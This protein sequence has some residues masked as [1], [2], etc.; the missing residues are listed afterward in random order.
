LKRKDKEIFISDMTDRLT[1]AR[2]TFLVDYQGLDVEAMNALRAELKKNQA[3]LFVVKNRLVKRACKD[4]DTA[5]IMEEFRGPCALTIAYDEIIAPAKVLVAREKKLDHLTI[6][7]GQIAGKSI[8]FK[9]IK[10]LA[11]LPGREVLLAQA[12]SA[13]QAVPASV[14][15]VLNAVMVNFLN[16]LKA[17][18][19]QQKDQEN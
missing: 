12:L 15:R 11:A 9:E 5:S 7:A 14:V 6:K 13:M 1:R 4:T 17:I 8:D 10:R 3:E 16:V 19:N 2:A 18:E